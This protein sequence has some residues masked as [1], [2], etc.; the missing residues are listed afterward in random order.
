[1]LF[2]P[3][4]WKQEFI[5]QIL[6]YS[7]IFGK[8][9]CVYKEI[10]WFNV[11]YLAPLPVCLLQ[12]TFLV[13]STANSQLAWGFNSSD[14]CEE[15]AYP[16]SKLLPAKF[17]LIFKILLV[18]PCKAI[19]SDL[20]SNLISMTLYQ[21]HQISL[22]MSN[23]INWDKLATPLFFYIIMYVLRDDWSS[24]CMVCW[25][26]TYKYDTMIV[27]DS[28]VFINNV[29]ILKQLFCQCCQC[30]STTLMS[31]M[32]KIHDALSSSSCPAKAEI[33]TV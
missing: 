15:V 5:N 21:K 31:L 24:R 3:A 16:N 20:Y 32:A 33:V 7:F 27:V 10:L 13:R 30:I 29:L 8:F 19:S 11:N 17:N 1:M 26:Y 14:I 25:A 6:M 4:E 9:W 23:I 12:I 18:L 22:T 28:H 2:S